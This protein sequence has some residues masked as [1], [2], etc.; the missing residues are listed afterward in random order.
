V[1]EIFAEM[2]WELKGSINK[3]N[4]VLD[5]SVIEDGEMKYI[6][7]YYWKQ[8]DIDKKEFITRRKETFEIMKRKDKVCVSHDDKGKLH[9]FF[10]D[11]G[12]IVALKGI[13]EEMIIDSAV[14]INGNVLL[15]LVLKRNEYYSAIRKFINIAHNRNFVVVSEL[16][17]GQV[18]QLAPDDAGSLFG[19]NGMEASSIDRKDIESLLWKYSN[20]GTFDSRKYNKLS[21]EIGNFIAFRSNRNWKDI[22][23]FLAEKN[24]LESIQEIYEGSKF[25][26]AITR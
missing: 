5:V 2:K 9:Y 24:Q 12:K 17:S 4:P 21:G 8:G 3:D 20:Y 14:N 15:G 25:P 13:N 22:L 10:I 16:S 23:N 18:E 1:N 7:R 11:Q 6:Y 19:F 26:R